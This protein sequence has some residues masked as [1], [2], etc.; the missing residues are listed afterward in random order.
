MNLRFFTFWA[1][2]AALDERV[3]CRQLDPMRAWGFDGTVFHPR[4]F[5]NLPP[6]LSD[7]YLAIKGDFGNTTHRPQGGGD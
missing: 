6:Y 7:G 3:L 1:I 5:P 2:N 4:F